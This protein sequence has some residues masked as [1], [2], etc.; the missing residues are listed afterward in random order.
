M[1]KFDK[2]FFDKIKKGE[3]ITVTFDSGI[4][5]GNEKKLTVT[6]KNLV[7]KGK[8]YESEKITFLNV[9]N[10]N[11]VKYYAYKRKDDGSIGFAI[12]DMA[13]SNFQVTDKMV[14]GGGVKKRSL[15]SMANLVV[16][17]WQKEKIKDWYTKNYPT[18]DMGEELND[19]VA[20]ADLMNALNNKKEIYKIMGVGDSVIRERLFE[21]LSQIYGVSYDDI[22][23]KWLESDYYAKG[24]YVFK[25][26]K[27]EYVPTKFIYTIGGL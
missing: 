10:P 15:M 20:F 6:S 16:A 23:K 12:G 11:G 19:K 17:D 25:G 27:Y 14:K 1:A 9:E 3:S 5:K 7:G 18:D 26:N 2:E 13:I 8:S 4:K 21:R 24:G 22:Y